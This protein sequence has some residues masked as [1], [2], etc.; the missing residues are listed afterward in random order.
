MDNEAEAP[1][2]GTGGELRMRIAV[3]GTGGV[4]GYFGG[5]LAEAGEE[6]VFIARGDHLRAL[7][8]RGLRVESTRGDFTVSPARATDDLKEIGPVDAVLVGVKSWQVADAARALRP[9]IGP[10][11]IVVPLQNGVD[12]PRQLAEALGDEH[13][14]GGVCRIIAYIAGPGHIRHSGVDPYI[15]FG[16][17][18]GRSHPG[19]ERLRAA[20]AR[21]TGL[22]V[23]VPSDIRVT[24]WRKFLLIAPLSGLGAVT[25]APVGVLR[26]LPET[27]ALLERALAEIYVLGRAQGVALPEN[28]VEQTL[29]FIDALPPAGT[30]SMQRDII[31]GKPSELEAQNGAVVRMAREAGIETPVH[32]FIYAALVALE[33]R[34]RGELSFSA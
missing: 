34:A 32:S 12:A 13:A 18:D 9:L 5:R 4:G 24:L 2:W 6:V 15:A 21:A 10:E 16:S 7:R 23:E 11:T 26:S 27:R 17:L 29:S 28:T 14:L 22:T 25:R 19:A 8:E 30:A 1:L 3:F 20:F 31:D 33:R